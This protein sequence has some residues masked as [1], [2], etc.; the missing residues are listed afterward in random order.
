VP[1][2]IVL[3]LLL[4]LSFVFLRLHE[5]QPRLVDVQDYRRLLQ[6]ILFL[7]RGNMYEL[8]LVI[9]RSN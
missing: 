5:Q 2:R 1:W 8:R 4:T 7:G 9:C 6:E 3:W